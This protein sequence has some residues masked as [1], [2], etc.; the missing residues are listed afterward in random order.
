MPR[1]L[2]I[3]GGGMNMRAKVQVDI[4]GPMTLPEYDERIR[5]YA[6]ELGVEIEIFHSNMTKPSE[7]FKRQIY[8]TFQDDHVAM[9]LIPF[10]G[11]GHLLWASD[12]PHPD[13]VWPN[14]RAAIERQMHHLPPEM[15]RKLTRDNAA[16]LY[17]L[18]GS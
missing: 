17:G 14:S 8:A 5:G 11:E 18:G 2:V 13:S 7:L 12:Y 4:F 15:R 16:A 3:H 6:K 10:F 1:V 9:S